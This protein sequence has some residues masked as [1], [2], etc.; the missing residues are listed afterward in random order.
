MLVLQETKKIL[1]VEKDVEEGLE[2]LITHRIQWEFSR[3]W[4]RHHWAK[5]LLLK[6]YRMLVNNRFSNLTFLFLVQYVLLCPAFL[7]IF[8][9]KVLIIGLK[10]SFED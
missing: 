8:V 3:N 4:S 10:K 2:T 9:T 1:Q 6:V 7:P 5:M